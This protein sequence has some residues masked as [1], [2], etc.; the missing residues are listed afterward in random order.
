MHIKFGFSNFTCNDNSLINKAYIIYV[1]FHK[2]SHAAYRL[3]ICTVIS[4][5]V[6]KPGFFMPWS[7]VMY[8]CSNNTQN[9]YSWASELG[10]GSTRCGEIAL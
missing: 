9:V 3:E 6:R 10:A 5:G 4:I 2:E 8:I 7:V 1:A